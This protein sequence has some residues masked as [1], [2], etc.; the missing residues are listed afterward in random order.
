MV[1]EWNIDILTL[2]IPKYIITD[3][4]RNISSAFLNYNKNDIL[5]HYSCAAH[6]LQL[7]I[8]D[9]LKENN[10]TGILKK[11]RSIVTHY[12]HSNK[13]WERLQQ[14]QFRLKRPNHKLIQMVET[15]W[16]SVFLMLE[17]I[18]EQRE[19]IV[20]DLP[21]SGRDNFTS[22]EWK[23][24]NCYVEILKPV[25]EA[26]KELSQE[27]IPTFSMI[28]P[29]VY[30]IDTK[31]NN[32]I[33]HNINTTTGLG[34]A[35][36]LK[37]SMANRFKACKT[38]SSYILETVIDPRFKTILMAPQEVE[39]VN[40]LLN[41]EVENLRPAI[42]TLEIIKTTTP[43]STVSASTN[44][45]WDILHERSLTTSV[46]NERSNNYFLLPTYIR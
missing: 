45:L 42:N 19:A 6:T 29:I 41:V 36:S 25:L 28:N 12:N 30:T 24:I 21:Y 44:S 13:S 46:S 9:A 43:C 7:S 20:L 3:N 33:A 17:R 14:I 11:C 32:Y 40:L 8:E 2:K 23:L 35:R 1:N 18:I 39:K 38:N 15:R 31:L 10:M 22:S 34:F 16:N 37:K 26:T 5:H 4:A 27:N